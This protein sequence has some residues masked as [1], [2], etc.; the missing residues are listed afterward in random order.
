MEYQHRGLAGRAPRAEPSWPTVI[1]TTLRLWLERHPVVIGGKA[2]HIKP[3]ALAAALIVSLAAVAAGALIGVGVISVTKPVRVSATDRAAQSKTSPGPSSAASALSASVATRDQ[4]AQWIAAQVA[5]SAIVAC[6][7]AMCATLQAG[8]IPAARLL[9]L[10]DAAADPLG[11]D[12]VVATLAVRTEFGARLASVYAPAV[13][14]SFGSGAGRIDI[15]AIAPL[16]AAAYESALAS[17][18]RARLAAGSQLLHNARIALSASAK[19]ALR[20]G[21]VDSRLLLT[22]AALAGQQPVR[23]LAFT[24]LSPGG[25]PAIP[26]RGAVIAPLKDRSRSGARLRMMRTF[27]DAQR[28]PFVPLRIILDGTSSLNFEYAAPIPL[29]LL[30]AP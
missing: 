20:D 1:A 23:V 30:G 17:D 16:G 26:L 18:R 28:S 9:V 6:D 14:A 25:N 2:V 7:P 22:L 19:A 3:R 4:A 5:A 12:V 10:G 8:G 21:E 27:L 11:S 13:I 24:D 15:R 29:G